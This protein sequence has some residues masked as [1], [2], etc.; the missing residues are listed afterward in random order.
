M[1]VKKVISSYQRFS[2]VRIDHFIWLKPYWS[3]QPKETEA[4]NNKWIKGHDKNFIEA[5][6]K[7]LGNVNLYG[8]I[9]Y[10]STEVK[11]LYD[12]SN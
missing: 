11:E 12:Y 3:I 1:V 9:G 4:K 10:L 2:Y 7:N 8:D 5:L 6:H